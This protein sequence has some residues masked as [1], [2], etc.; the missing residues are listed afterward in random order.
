VTPG[1]L[2]TLTVER[3]AAGGRMIARHDGAV[4]LVSGTLPGE[5]VEA[6]V[7]KVQ[8][9]TV[10]AAAS[11]IL[12]ASP[13]RVGPSTGAGSPGGDTGGACGG[14]VFAHIRY[15]RQL[16]LKRAIVVD[17][18]SR[19]ARLPLDLPSVTA[20][21]ADGYRMRARL[22]V[23]DGL[24]GFFREGTH[25]LCAAG[26]TRQLLTSTVEVLDRLAARLKDAAAGVTEI[27]LAESRDALQRAVHF[28]LADRA[29]PSRLGPAS[30]VDG[31]T[32]AS[33]SSGVARGLDLWGEATVSDVLE[34]GPSFT[35][36]RHSRAFFQ[37]NRFLLQDLTS[38][39][40]ASIDSGPVVDLYAGVGL[41]SV[42]AAAAGKGPVMAVE[43]ERVAADDL[44]RNAAPFRD[45][46]QCRH[47]PVEEF[48]R[49]AAR[50]G[51]AET[52]IVDPPRTGLSRE[53]LA[54]ALAYR[55]ARIVYVSC[56]VATLARDSRAIVDAGYAMAGVRAFD[57][58]PNTAHVETVIRFERSR[59]E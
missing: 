47:Q 1:A 14:C 40:L 11:T 33:C 53:A 15:E 31:L 2:L 29:E 24:V 52:L 57:L 35:L 23:R 20:S 5:T 16:E 59:R 56:D 54:G 32:G 13:D 4:V 48:L 27:E 38:H 58:F 50:P 9:G 22:H 17:A 3:P 21:P 37:A 7:E 18:F 25:R 49:G 45:A 28:E 46:L 8:R 34:A 26:P 55:A 42:A 6:R 19:L 51:R 10:W 30:L 43:G 12:A 36:A 44:K 39:V 41:F